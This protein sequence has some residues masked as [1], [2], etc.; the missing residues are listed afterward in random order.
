MYK[1][2]YRG[3]PAY[4]RSIR[5]DWPASSQGA[6]ACETWRAE[7]RRHLDLENSLIIDVSPPDAPEGPIPRIYARVRDC[8]AV[9]VAYNNG[10]MEREVSR[11]RLTKHSIS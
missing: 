4:A 3:A 9:M 1:L 10:N 6:D 7:L 2:A 8:A 11:T 5:I